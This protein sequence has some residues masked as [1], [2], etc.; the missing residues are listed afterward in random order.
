MQG[1]LWYKGGSLVIPA[2]G[3]LRQDIIQELHSS[4]LAAHNGVDKTTELIMRFYWWPNMRVD[5]R[6]HVR[7]CDACQRNKSRST[8]PAGKLNPLSIPEDKFTCYSMDHVVGLPESKMHEDDPVGFDAILVVVDRLSK[9]T[10]LI[11]THT[12]ATAETTAREFFRFV[13]SRFG[14]PQEI[15]SDR[16]PIFTSKF[17]R[18][19]NSLYGIRGSYSTAYHPQ[20]DGQTE[21]VNRVLGD[22]LRNLVGYDMPHQWVHCLPA[23]EFAI[24]NSFHSS[25][26]TTPFRLAYGK[27]PRMPLSAVA[28]V[29]IKCAR[30]A[31]FRND[32]QESI[33]SARQ[34][35]QSAQ[36]RAKAYYD[37]GRRDETFKLGTQ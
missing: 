23:A 14:V 27:D 8:K 29:D 22:M 33:R 34:H 15:V 10:T 4:S 37:A 36:S 13:V 12:T 25:I 18:E 24:N 32:W 19:L 35:M 26:G 6:D 30:V 2:V 1:E 5:I 3:T 9:M 31:K 17:Q 11:P 21:R 20:S 7:T 28:T 16:G